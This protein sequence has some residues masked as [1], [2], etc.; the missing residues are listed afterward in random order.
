M[1]FI[2]KIEFTN[3]IVDFIYP[4]IVKRKGYE[5]AYNCFE[6]DNDEIDD[7]TPFVN[8]K[9]EKKDDSIKELSDKKW[10]DMTEEEKNEDILTFFTMETQRYDFDRTY[11]PYGEYDDYRFNNPNDLK[12][13]D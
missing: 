13:D 7:L 9:E 6:E 3:K 12:Y 4:W 1:A 8:K 5:S 10:N 2:N 11:R